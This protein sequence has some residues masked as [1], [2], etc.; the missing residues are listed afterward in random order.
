MLLNGRIEEFQRYSNFKSLKDFNN[1]IEMFLSIYKK[2]FTKSEFIAFN[3]LRKY[4]AKVIGVANA[5]IKTV[6]AGIQDKDTAAGVSE[7]TFKRMKRKAVKLGILTIEPTQRN[8][9]SQSTNLW[10]FNRFVSNSNKIDPPPTSGEGRKK[11]EQKEKVVDQL[12]P[13]ETGHS[14]YTNLHNINN[15][16]NTRSFKYIKFV[17]KIVNQKYA[18]LFQHDLRKI[19]TRVTSACKQA[20]RTFS[21]VRISKTDKNEIGLVAIDSLYRYI[22][23][24]NKKNETM[25]LDEQC[26]IVYSVTFSQIEQLK[27]CQDPIFQDVNKEKLLNDEKHSLIVKMLE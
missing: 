27:V 21:D 24:R 19:W 16:L 10:I 5:S 22:V 6:L 26:S 17:P 20:K 8:N 2:E 11:P 12:A 15:H 9:K 3:R 13:L 7:S 25:P 23:E 1:N 14:I 18:S 4:C